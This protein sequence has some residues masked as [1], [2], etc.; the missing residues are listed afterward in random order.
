MNSTN[1]LP[2]YTCKKDFHF[3]NFDGWL[4]LWF[5]FFLN[6]EK[7]N[8]LEN[9]LLFLILIWLTLSS[10]V[11]KSFSSDIKEISSW[12]FH[13]ESCKLVCEFVNL[14]LLLLGGVMLWMFRH[15]VALVDMLRC[16]YVEPSLQKNK[17][18]KFRSIQRA[19][20][21]SERPYMMS[22]NFSLDPPHVLYIGKSLSHSL[23]PLTPFVTSLKWFFLNSQTK[24]LIFH[25]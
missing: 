24:F 17:E 4:L 16:K 2:Q 3:H 20:M 13:S 25:N 19:L 8:N 15:T 18:G 5:L 23:G 11:L 9:L 1:A 10:S 12:C 7:S 21:R 14:L 22:Q 6:S